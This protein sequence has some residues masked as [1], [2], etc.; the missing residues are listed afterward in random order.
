MQMNT[1]CKNV[2]YVLCEC[3]LSKHA[4]F[5]FNMDD[6]GFCILHLKETKSLMFKVVTSLVF[7]LPAQWYMLLM[8]MILSR[9]GRQAR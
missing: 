2:F 7:G 8:K 1:R 9:Q 5:M 6:S 4:I 3:T